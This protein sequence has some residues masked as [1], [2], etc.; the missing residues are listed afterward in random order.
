MI[1]FY[2]TLALFILF[3]SLARAQFIDESQVANSWGDIPSFDGIVGRIYVD[4]GGNSMVPWFEGEFTLDF[5]LR[6]TWDSTST[7]TYTVF[8]IGAWNTNYRTLRV[9]FEQSGGK[10]VIRIADGYQGGGNWDLTSDELNYQSTF[11]DKWKHIT[12]T[13]DDT[14]LRLYIDGQQAGQQNFTFWQVQHNFFYIGN[15]SN[16]PSVHGNFQGQMS[17]FRMWRGKALNNTEVTYIHPRTFDGPLSFSADHQSLYNLLALN[18]Y[19]SSDS[20]SGVPLYQESFSHPDFISGR[21]PVVGEGDLTFNSGTLHPGHPIKPHSLEADS[22]CDQVTL[23]W[24]QGYKV[25]TSAIFRKPLLGNDTTF[26]GYTNDTTFVDTDTTL[27]GNQTYEYIVR[28]AWKTGAGVL[29]SLDAEVIQ[30][31][32]QKYAQVQNF[33]LTPDCEGNVRL[34]WDDMSLAHPGS[35]YQLQ[36]WFEDSWDTLATVNINQT[37]YIYDVPIE[38][39]GQEVMYRI[40]LLGDDCENYSEVINGT[41]NSPVTTAPTGVTSAIDGDLI[42]VNWDFTQAGAPADVFRIFR[43]EVGAG[44]FDLIATNIAIEER[45]YD[46]LEAVMCIAYE[47]QVEAFNQCGSDSGLSGISNSSNLPLNFDNVFT[48]GAY[49]DASKG[50]FNNKVLLEWGINT[51]K[52]ADVNSFEI[53]RRKQDQAFALLAT[54]NNANAKSYE[55]VN[56]EANVLYSYLIRAVGNCVSTPV[57]SDSL[58]TEGFRNNTGIVSGKVSFSGGN[59]VKGVEV[60]VASEETSFTNS[61]QFN[62]IDQHLQST[63][64]L[65]DSLYFKPISFDAWIRPELMLSGEKNVIVSFGTGLLSLSLRKMKPNLQLNGKAIGSVEEM[66]I[67]SLEYDSTLKADTWYHLAFN[68]DPIAGTLELF[69]NGML[70]KSTTVATTLDWSSLSVATTDS[71]HYMGHSGFGDQGFFSGHLDEIRVWSTYRDAE[72]IKRDFVRTLSGK[73]AHLMGY[74]NLDEGFGEGV[75]DLSKTGS[76]FNKNNF[77]SPTGHFPGWSETVPSYEQLHPSGITNAQGNYIVTG[78]KY[79]GSGNIFSLTPILGVHQFNPSD[80][81]LFIGDSNPVHNAVDFTDISSF[82]FTGKITYQNTDFPVEGAEIFVDNQKVVDGLGQATKTDQFGE[83]DIDVP[84]GN[85]YIKVVK[86]GHVFSSGGQ[87]PIPSEAQP[88]LTHNFQDDVLGR[89]FTDVTTVTVAGRFAGGSVEASKPLGFNKSINNIGVGT[90]VLENERGFDVDF[91]SLE[92]ISSTVNVSTDPESGEYMMELLPEVYKIVSAGNDH[93]EIDEN[94]LGLLDLTRIPEN[95]LVEQDTIIT[96]DI[97][98]GDTII[99]AVVNTF[100]YDFG[101]NFIYHERPE[102][103]VFGKND[104]PFTGETQLAFKDPIT[105]ENDTIDLLVN[106]PFRFPVF[107][108]NSPY[109][110]KIKVEAKYFNYDDPV[111]TIISLVPVPNATVTITNNLEAEEPQQVFTT[112]QEG[113]VADYAV[114]RAGIPNMSQD[115]VSGN[116]FTKTMTITAQAGDFDVAWND[117]EAFR[118]YVLGSVDAGGANFVTAGV[119]FPRFVLRDPPGSRSYAYLEEGSEYTVSR[120]YSIDNSSE[121]FNGFEFLRGYDFSVTLPVVGTNLSSEFIF[122]ETYGI[123]KKSE[124]TRSGKYEETFTFSRRFSTSAEPNNVGSMADVFIGESINYFFR[125][126]DDLA[127][128]PRSYADSAGLIQLDPGELNDPNSEFVLAIKKGLAFTEDGEPTMFSYSQNFI[129]SDLIP[130]YREKIFELLAKP[131]YESKV[132]IDHPFYG[133]SNNARVWRGES[134]YSLDPLHPSYEYHGAGMDSVAWINENISQWMSALAANEAAKLNAGNNVEN[135]SF[136]GTGGA[137]ENFVELSQTNRSEQSFNRNYN[138]YFSNNLGATF[139][140]AGFI[141]MAET[142]L[143]ISTSLS[144]EGASTN[145]MKWGYVLDD[146]EQ[147]DFY[148]VDVYKSRNLIITDEEDFL[149]SGNFDDVGRNVEALGYGDAGASLGNLGIVHILRNGFDKGVGQLVGQALSISQTIATA[150]AYFVMFDHYKR[151]VDDEDGRFQFSDANSSPIFRVR[152]GQ[153]RCP[154][155]GPEWTSFYVNPGTLKPYQLHVGTQAHEIPKIEVEPAEV[156]NIPANEPAVFTLKLS[157]NSTT[158]QGVSFQLQQDQNSNPDGAVMNIDGFGIDRIIFIPQGQTVTKTL[159]VEKGATTNL[160]FENLQLVMRSLC[161]F[162]PDDDL[163]DISDTVSFTARFIPACSK[164]AFGNLQQDWV[165]NLANV[166][167][168]RIEVTNYNINVPTFERIVLQYL[169]PGSTPTTIR[170]F[171]NDLEAYNADPGTR[172]EL[173]EGR[174]EMTFDWALN[175]L[176]DGE[177]TLILKTVCTDGSEYEAE[178]LTG[179]IDRIAPQPFGTPLPIDGVLDIGENIL[180]RFNEPVDEGDL[181]ARKDYIS[182]KGVLNGTD[183]IDNPSLLH[184]VS[185]HFDGKNQNMSVSSP[186]NLGRDAY[187]VEMWVKRDRTGAETLLSIGDGEAGSL[188]LGFTTDDYLQVIIEGQVVTS[189]QIYNQTGE[190]LHL[191]M[192]HVAQSTTAE[193]AIRLIIARDAFVEEML[194]KVDTKQGVHGPL[195]IAA[196]PLQNTSFQGNIHELRIWNLSRNI[197]QI[198]SQRYTK[199]TGYER[200]LYSLW[201]INEATGN[202]VKDI[203]FGRTATISA[204]WQ[205][206]RNGKALSFDGSGYFKVPT[207]SM[208]FSDQADFTIEFW[209]K[210]QGNGE[211]Q[212]LMSNGGAAGLQN[213]NSW[214]ILLTPD[215]SLQ[216]LHND[217]ITRVTAPDIISTNWHHFALSVNRRSNLSVYLDGELLSTE[218]SSLFNGWAASH[219]VVGSGWKLVNSVD[220]LDQ[221]FNGEVDEIRVWNSARTKQHIQQLRNHALSGNEYGLRA[222]F[223]FEDVRIAD[224]S[225]SNETLDNL[226]NDE[227]L[228]SAGNGEL[229]GGAT[230]V[231]LSPGIKLGRPEVDIPF[232]YLTNR[233]ELIVIPRIEAAKIENTTLNISVKR[234]KDLHNNQ[235]NSTISWTAFVNQNRL[236]WEQP[237]VFIEKTVGVAASFTVQLKNIGGT[238]EQY[239]IKN[240]PQWLTTSQANGSLD[241]KELAEITFKINPSLNIGTYEHLVDAVGSQGFNERIRVVV[242]VAAPVPDW[243]VDAKQ[244]QHSASVIGQLRISG[245]ISTDEDDLVACFINNKPRGVAPVKYIPEGDAYLVFLDVYHQEASGGEMT[246]KV[247]DA[248]TGNIYSDVLPKL[249]FSS[250]AVFGLVSAPTIIEALESIEQPLELHSGWNWISFNLTHSNFGDLNHELRGISAAP[251]DIIKSQTAFAQYSETGKWLGDLSELSVQSMYKVRVNT[252]QT[253]TIRGEPVNYQTLEIPILDGWNWVSYPLPVNSMVGEALSS[254]TFNEGDLIKSQ[255]QFAIFDPVLGW[256]GS[257]E[258]MHPGTG[259]MLR[260]SVSGMLVYPTPSTSLRKSDLQILSSPSGFDL[261]PEEE[262]MNLIAIVEADIHQD[263]WILVFQNDE[264][265]GK[266]SSKLIGNERM[267]FVSMNLSTTDRAISYQLLSAK[268]GELTRLN[269]APESIVDGLVGQLV[270]P[271]KFTLGETILIDDPDIRVFPNPFTDKMTI[272]NSNY[273]V[274]VTLFTMDGRQI[275]RSMLNAYET[276]EWTISSEVMEGTYLLLFKDKLGDTHSFRMIKITN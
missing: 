227:I 18:F 183:L 191:A 244:Y 172:K 225:I 40:Q 137:Y 56:A 270:S 38:R 123:G 235:M 136:D 263:D 249:Q 228:V 156:V 220:S 7:K 212:C 208:V 202:T 2:L 129:L 276:Q 114:F 16:W 250:G 199:M 11:K 242:K 20:V 161:Q 201:P 174:A 85:H 58:H 243:A 171:Y 67:A 189:E 88:L 160:D 81:N 36:S 79:A 43:R 200:G 145:R 5:W 115:V 177:Y 8:S 229:F 157:N 234:V 71:T 188:T 101:R 117:G 133:S 259:Y 3:Q 163:V 94:D 166:D 90:I 272:I 152:G 178:R 275:L 63:G 195:L 159:T 265:I 92:S 217:R 109:P 197:V 193:E 233:D 21:V 65:K 14:M 49:F 95:P 132:A 125:E 260:S 119:E 10:Y 198:N 96:E 238:E 50:Y 131:E 60:R 218:S 23:R 17:N 48:N 130:S 255:Q 209:F 42:R 32:L 105:H 167:T 274:E 51:E 230:V 22:T 268:T 175:S 35:S 76:D 222:Y 232:D 180:M 187:T 69:L 258:A 47:Y 246:F 231:N 253:A 25:V 113:L 184:D 26:L 78:I 194:Q 158:E 154:Y 151:A 15:D 236:A 98:D 55:D 185:L 1:R 221:H 39:I 143:D 149:N 128:V 266:G 126:T 173:I 135:I 6:C 219:M 211:S 120:S 216:I 124:T 186:I 190:W 86:K 64:F 103:T 77:F 261:P 75:Y 252:N 134:S 148:S 146:N 179:T 27:V 110:I 264:L 99:S 24:S 169:R 89:S 91:S 214:R 127:L 68:F 70:V 150:S 57:V 100:E 19:P 168:M 84:I 182:L 142:Q 139:N 41:A 30:I 273:P 147:G 82:R 262:T 164:V 248:S 239:E 245:T 74:F 33:R 241:A 207:G 210:A 247:F 204:T 215:R 162:D 269:E 37:E 118:G 257:L 97:I 256:V 46:D 223:P 4:D 31:K 170:S 53:Y 112:N 121:N 138:L 213:S 141:S 116:S 80:I 102:I 237:S 111:D 165:A 144:T 226:A 224:P 140:G 45:S 196:S 28:S 54:L 12:V 106:N 93:Y 29:T 267:F 153:S 59:V 108:M 206:S 13:Y 176:N 155:E 62:G 254:I 107:K 192:S 52:K 61:I 104:G 122:D 9:F 271:F 181:A 240:I 87:W 72:V 44:T 251:G 34:Q 83:F 203:A 66:T 73:E 205:V